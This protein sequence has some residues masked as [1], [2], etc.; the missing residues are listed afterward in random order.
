[1]KGKANEL[2][3][4]SPEPVLVLSPASIAHNCVFISPFNVSS[5]A[6]TPTQ[7]APFKQSHPLKPLLFKHASTS[8]TVAK[9]CL[10]TS[11]SQ[12]NPKLSRSHQRLELEERNQMD[13]VQCRLC[14]RFVIK[15]AWFSAN[16]YICRT[17]KGEE[18]LLTHSCV[19]R[20]RS[21]LPGGW[22]LND[23]ELIM[24]FGHTGPI[25]L[26]ALRGQQKKR[27]LQQAGCCMLCKR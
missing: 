12:Y 20:R 2:E 24:L 16:K 11:N 5:T 26:P 8:E 18:E 19:Q 17:L 27:S 25:V 13:T 7:T 9:E 10:S 1:M 21:A 22:D 3:Y 14:I 4:I 15:L 23:G 6:S